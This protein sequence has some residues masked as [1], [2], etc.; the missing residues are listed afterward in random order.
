MDYKD[1]TNCMLY[2]ENIIRRSEKIEKTNEDSNFVIYVQNEEGL[3]TYSFKQKSNNL[4]AYIRN[5]DSKNPR[6]VAVPI[7]YCRNSSIVYDEEKNGFDISIDFIEEDST[8]FYKT[9]IGKTYE[10]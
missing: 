10:K 8:S 5:T 2:I 3:S 1:S 9:F 7:G 4:Y 6:Y